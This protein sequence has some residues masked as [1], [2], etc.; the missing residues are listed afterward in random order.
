MWHGSRP[1]GKPHCHSAGLSRRDP[2]RFGSLMAHRNRCGNRHGCKKC[3]RCLPARKPNTERICS[4]QPS[5]RS[6]STFDPPGPQRR[7][8]APRPPA[9]RSPERSPAGPGRSRGAQRSPRRPRGPA[10]ARAG[11]GG[12]SEGRRRPQPPG[13]RPRERTGGTHLGPGPAQRGGW[14]RRWSRALPGS[15]SSSG[16]APPASAS[17]VNKPLR[18]FRQPGP[19]HRIPAVFPLGNTDR[20][21]TLRPPRDTGELRERRRL[22][23]AF[24]SAGR[25]PGHHEV[26]RRRALPAPRDVGTASRRP[27][28]C[29]VGGACGGGRGERRGGGASHPQRA[30]RFQPERLRGARGRAAMSR[31]HRSRWVRGRGQVGAGPGG[32]GAGAERSAARLLANGRRFP[33]GSRISKRCSANPRWLWASFAISASVVSG[34]GGSGAAL[35]VTAAAPPAPIPELR[36]GGPAGAEPYRQ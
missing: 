32:C 4:Q 36:R 2:P 14:G 24:L 26:R 18:H 23:A 13:A 28:R 7:C 1:D 29:K 22:R 20:A 9:G 11:S 12:S 33:A 21:G 3:H 5:K 34:T 25:A 17:A 31:L 8:A 35:R 6:P 19:P 27:G 15:A 10:G 30:R 16:P